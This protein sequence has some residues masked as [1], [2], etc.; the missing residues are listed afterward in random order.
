MVVTFC[1][2]SD[3]KICAKLLDNRRL[4]KAKLEAFQI[5]N[6]LEKK[7][8]GYSNHPIILMWAD[9]IN[10]LKYFYNCH[11]DEWVSRG[12][13]N[14]MV[15]FDL[16][17]EDYSLPWW[18]SNR[19]IHLSHMASL[20]RKDEKFYTPLFSKEEGID[21]YLKYGYIWTG[22]LEES[23]INKMKNNVKQPLDKICAAFGTGVPA[24]YRITK[25]E[26]DK[27]VLSGKKINPKTG[28]KISESG[29]IFK[30]LEKA[31]KYYSNSA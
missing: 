13:N 25:D 12:K 16:S 30:D 10:G 14:N 15:K 2:D 1:M 29:S 23:V 24:Q 22:G 20:M 26:V 28:R 27:W 5:I 17:N 19:Q 31:Y 18:F 7:R 9:N 8:K 3:P 11:I 6:V 21:E 4:N